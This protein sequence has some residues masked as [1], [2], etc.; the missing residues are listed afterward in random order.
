MQEK[1]RSLDL[2]VDLDVELDLDLD[3]DLDLFL[4]QSELINQPLDNI[5]LTCATHILTIMM[6]IWSMRVLKTKKDHCITT[7]VN[8]YCFSNILLSVELVLFTLEVGFPFNISAICAI[9]NAAFITLSTF[10]RLVP[11]A[12]V[13]LRYIMVCHPALFI[14]WGRE[15]GIW[16]WILGSV[17]FLCLAI[18]IYMMY[19]SSIAYRFLRCAGREEDFG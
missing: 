3:S 2:D 15:K 16:K 12:I 11:L 4:D 1:N 13:L 8:W 10:T 17:I 5:W 19:T 6:N 7:L 9:R 14:D 18:W